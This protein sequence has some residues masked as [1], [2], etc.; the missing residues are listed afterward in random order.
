M[1]V[2]LARANH[3]QSNLS[4]TNT[5]GTERSVRRIRVDLS[6]NFYVRTCVK[7]SFA[8]KIEA[9]HKRSLVSVKVDH[10][11]TSHLTSALFTL[12]LFYLRD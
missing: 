4:N 2:L 11:S 6:R 7:F 5:E 1:F 10:L 3:V 9:M 8:T 12:P